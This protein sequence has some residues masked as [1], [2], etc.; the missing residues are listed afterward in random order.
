MTISPHAIVSPR[1]HLGADVEIGPFSVVHDGVE[2][3]AGSRIGAHCEIGAPGPSGVSAPGLVIGAGAL[4]RSHSVFYLGS[5]YGPGL[6]T[7]HRVTLREGT[8][9]GQGVRIGTQCDIQGDCDIGDHVRLHSSVFVAKGSSIR[10]FAW[11]FPRVVLTNDPTPPSDLQRGCTV[12]EYAVVAA[13]AVL[14]PGVVLGAGAVVAAGACV[15]I[16]VP[17][18]MLA[19]GVPAR[20]VGPASAVRLRNGDGGPAYPWTRHFQRGYPEAL[21]RAWREGSETEDSHAP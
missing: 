3:G 11:L 16:D 17:P 21:A 18:G 12:G 19:R 8:R 14:L 4:V 9:C 15:G 20:L 1:A 5:N 10:R 13:A 2:I 6:E 7:G